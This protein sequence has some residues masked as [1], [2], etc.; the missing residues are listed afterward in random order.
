MTLVGLSEVGKLH[1]LPQTVNLLVVND[2][3]LLVSGRVYI[4]LETFADKDILHPHSHL[5]SMF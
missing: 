2:D 3:K 1:L 4:E 5:D